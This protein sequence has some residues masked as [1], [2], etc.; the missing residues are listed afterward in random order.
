MKRACAKKKKLY[1]AFI[2]SRSAESEH[3]YKTFKNKL[4]SILRLTEKT[5]FSTLLEQQRTNVKGTWKILNKVINKKYNK[6]TY[7][8]YFLKNNKR[9]SKKEDIANGFNHFFFTNVGTHLAKNI[10]LPDKDVSI[11]DYL[12]GEVGH[13]MFLNPVDDQKIIRTVQ[14]CKNKMS[15][16]YNDI[17]MSMVKQI[18]NQIVRP[19][20]HPAMYL[21]KRVYFQTWRLPL[22]IQCGIKYC[23][24]V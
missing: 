2:L 4:T 11:Y 21:F 22:S 19:F 18:I 3:K 20:V 7:P 9:I 12:E 24:T 14:S 10:P 5:Y 13:T 23:N 1:K 17:N 8:E 6:P 15:T 16:D